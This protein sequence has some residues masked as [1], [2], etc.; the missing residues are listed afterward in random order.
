M[1]GKPYFSIYEMSLFLENFGSVEGARAALDGFREK[2]EKAG[3]PGLHVNAVLWGNA[4]FAGRENSGGL[5]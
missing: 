1:E 4:Q 3:F 2:A 5:A